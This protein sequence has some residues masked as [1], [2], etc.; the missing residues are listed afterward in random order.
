MYRPPSFATLPKGWVLVER[1]Q[2]AGWERRTDLPV[3]RH[4]FGVVGFARALSDREIADYEL[5]FLGQ[6][7]ANPP[8]GGDVGTMREVW[9]AVYAFARH[10]AR[11][12]VP[13]LT[14]KIGCP[15]IARH[16]RTDA[17]AFMHTGGRHAA[18]QVH[19]APEAALLELTYLT[20]LFLHEIGHEI[21]TRAWARSEQE[22]ADKAVREFL[23]V[24]LRYKGPLL[25]EWVSRADARRIM[26]LLSTRPRRR[27]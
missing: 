14:L 13:R 3:S 7:S 5:T 6:S 20:G 16:R 11:K 23:G 25:L 18:G 15:V 17:R 12:Y 22:D 8:R 4:R 2:I 24:R 26:S 27:R 10:K 19:V 9:R 21:A 1:P